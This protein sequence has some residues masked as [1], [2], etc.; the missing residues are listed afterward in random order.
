LGYILNDVLDREKDRRHPIKVKRKPLANGSLT[1]LDACYTA[2]FFIVTLLVMGCYFQSIFLY[3]L[4]YLCCSV[5]YSLL[6]KSLVVLDIVSLIFLYLLRVYA[7]GE[8]I[9]V[10]VSLLMYFTTASLCLFL[11]V[12]KRNA[13]RLSAGVASRSVLQHYSERFLKRTIYGSALLTTLGYFVFSLKYHVIFLTTTPFVLLGLMRFYLISS[14][15]GE[16]DAAR[17]LLSDRT[18]F[19]IV[20]CWMVSVLVI[21]SGL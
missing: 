15:Q 13:E 1:L 17:I 5:S 14:G 18:L 2:L 8:A 11:L 19:L 9:G 12:N 20:L 10:P 6:F 21:L 7:G 3:T 16:E 4:F